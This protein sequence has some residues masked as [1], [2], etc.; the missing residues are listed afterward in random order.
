MSRDTAPRTVTVPSRDAAAHLLLSV[1]ATRLML[2]RSRKPGLE[3]WLG[4]LRA[5]LTAVLTT[6]EVDEVV[7]RCQAIER[8]IERAA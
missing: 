1:H 8:E 6:A 4:E 5:A 3:A 7:E 2:G